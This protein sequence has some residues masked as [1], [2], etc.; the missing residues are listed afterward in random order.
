MTEILI[1][2]GLVVLFF[3]AR[4]LP[5]IGKGLGEGIKS[6]RSAM[7]GDEP[8]HGEDDRTGAGGGPAK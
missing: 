6:F 7:R 2:A 4:R 1:L 3:G 5:E 8:G